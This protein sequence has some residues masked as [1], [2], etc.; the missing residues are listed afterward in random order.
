MAQPPS[1]SSST[2]SPVC[3]MSPVH[4]S[5]LEVPLKHSMDNTFVARDG[6]SGEL[7]CDDVRSMVMF[8]LLLLFLYI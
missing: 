8:L 3:S 7:P 6:E 1:R 4:S 5:D 2:I